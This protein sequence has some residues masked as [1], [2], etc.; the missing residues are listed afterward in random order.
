MESS[1]EK[2]GA[3]YRSIVLTADRE[4]QIEEHRID[5]YL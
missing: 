3:R 1:L 2:A 4:Q 5:L